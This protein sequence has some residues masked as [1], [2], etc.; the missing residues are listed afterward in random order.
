[1]YTTSRWFYPRGIEGEP[2]DCTYLHHP[3]EEA[4]IRYAHRYAKGLRF[5]RVIVQDD[6]GEILYEIIPDDTYDY[7]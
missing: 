5:C 2:M 3:T 7:R 6:T 1:M 4:A